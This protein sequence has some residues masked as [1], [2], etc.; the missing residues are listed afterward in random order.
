MTTADVADSSHGSHTCYAR[1]RSL[2]GMTNDTRH[3][4]GILGEDAAARHLEAAGYQVV[5]RNFRTRHGEL[6]IVAAD[7]RHLVFCE[8]KTRVA[9]GRRGPAGPLDAI[10]PA[11]R[12]RLRRMAAQWLVERGGGMGRE[13][14]RFD[15]IA[16][17]VS[18]RGKLIRL[19]H[20]EGAF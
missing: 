8:V 3:A 6:D 2:A 12:H 15:A 10:G 9:G 13:E 4:L 5:E 11:K 14:L 19:D 17:E 7:G 20:L 16:V 1:R 18:A